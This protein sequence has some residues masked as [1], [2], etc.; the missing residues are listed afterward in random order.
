M[1]KTGAREH[2]AQLSASGQSAA[3]VTAAAICGRVAQG[4]GNAGKGG[5]GKGDMVWGHM[6]RHT[7]S[8]D[9]GKWG[10]SQVGGK[11]CGHVPM[12]RTNHPLQKEERR[13][14]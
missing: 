9:G 7:P 6:A 4:K 2:L 14:G 12:W 10:E 3:G 8:V 1:R 5:V 11:G 13:K